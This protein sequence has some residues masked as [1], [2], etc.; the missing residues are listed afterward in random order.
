MILSAIAELYPDGKVPYIQLQSALHNVH[1]EN[2]NLDRE[3][4]QLADLVA[5]VSFCI[6]TM[7]GHLRRIKLNLTKFKQAI[8]V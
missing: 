1:I 4:L 7:L 3:G 8:R 5:K 6:R 2:P